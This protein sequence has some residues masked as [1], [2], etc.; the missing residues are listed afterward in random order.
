MTRLG[1][2]VFLTTTPI[3]TALSSWA[4]PQGTTKTSL[5][6]ATHNPQQHPSPLTTTTEQQREPWRIVLDLGR[7][8]LSRMPFDW[9]RSGARLPLVVPCDF[10]QESITTTTNDNSDQTSATTTTTTTTTKSNWVAP[11]SDTIS[12]TG[13]DGAVV[14][15]VEGGE[16]TINNAASELQLSLRFPQSLAKHDVSI[17]GGSELVLTARTYTQA[18]LDQL[19]QAY[20]Q[21]REATWQVGGA[22]NEAQRRQGAAKKWNEATQRWEKRHAQ[23]NVWTAAKNQLKYWKLKN[24]QDQAL[25]QRP[26]ANVLSSRG[27]LPGVVSKQPSTMTE[28]DP[29]SQQQHDGNNPMGAPGRTSNT[30]D[31]IYIAQ[32]GI[33]RLVDAK[34]GQPGPVMGTWSAQPITKSLY[35]EKN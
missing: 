1:L 24:Q 22:L 2:L 13:P 20:Y 9:A 34:T 25:R 27:A 11:R 30:G 6:P 35:R 28:N 8:P 26:D 21:A 4:A 3:A 16:W 12:F 23:E 19:N 31:G 7:E 5:N 18:E 29:T 33:V 32:G 15:P 10:V 17:A 14:R